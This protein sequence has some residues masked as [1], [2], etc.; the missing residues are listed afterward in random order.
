MAHAVY[1]CSDGRYYTSSEL[2]QQFERGDWQPCCWD[3][4]SGQEW[5]R[6]SA[7]ALLLLTPVPRS[8]LPDAVR[9]VADDCG[10]RVVDD[11]ALRDSG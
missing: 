9:V 3:A 2:W 7:D 5:V 8:S 6:A 11:R 1:E 10:T 4:D